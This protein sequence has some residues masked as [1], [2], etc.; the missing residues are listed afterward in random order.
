MILSEFSKVLQDHE[1]DIVKGKSSLDFLMEW[2][3]NI[4]SKR[5]KTNVE[6]IIHTEIALCE[7][8][9]GDFLLVAKSDSG[10]VLTKTLYE[11]CESFDRHVMRKW[12]QNKQATDFNM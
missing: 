4:L 11:F 12:L 5:P 2:I 1:Q 3:K 7:N 8:K 10:R 9:T 6:K